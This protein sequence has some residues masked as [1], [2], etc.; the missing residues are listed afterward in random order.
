M[1]ANSD[2]VLESLRESAQKDTDLE[3]GKVTVRP[4]EE[5]LRRSLQAASNA[6]FC[7]LC[8][9][10]QGCVQAEGAMTGYDP[11][12]TSYQHYYQQGSKPLAIEYSINCGAAGQT[13]VGVTRADCAAVERRIGNLQSSA[14]LAEAHAESLIRAINTA[15]AT[16][17]F[18]Y[19]VVV[20][21]GVEIAATIRSPA[22]VMLPEI[23]PTNNWNG[24][25]PPPPPPVAVVNMPGV[26]PGVGISPSP[27]PIAAPTPSSQQC[28]SGDNSCEG[29]ICHY[30]GPGEHACQCTRGWQI[31]NSRST[32][33]GYTEQTCAFEC[34]TGYE[35]TGTHTCGADG[36]FTGGTCEP[37]ACTGGLTIANS[38]TTCSGVTLEECSYECNDGWEPTGSHICTPNGNFV[39]GACTTV[40]ACTA[41]EDDCDGR[42]CTHLGVNSHA[43]YCDTGNQ[44][45]NSQ[46]TCVGYT[47]Q[48]CAFECNAGYEPAGTHT[49]GA[50]GTFTGGT[51][52]PTACTGG[53]TIAN[54]PT[55]CSGVTLEECSYECNE[56]WQASGGS[57]ICM[58][59][60][61]FV[62]GSCAEINSCDV[63]EADDC[64]GRLCTHLSPGVHACYCDTGTTIPN[65]PTSCLGYTGQTCDFDCLPGYIATGIHTCAANGGFIGGSCAPIDCPANS[66]GE[67]V[68]LGCTCNDGFSGAIFATS[69]APF[70]TGSCEPSV[71]S[72]G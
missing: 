34:N 43:C 9:N 52:E 51:C 20:S 62:G 66:N 44:I 45:E 61:N 37:S 65:S 46:S 23:A 13:Y 27:T 12:P 7:V 67:N 39:G 25:P 56:G 36:T 69:T 17:N 70:F 68:G 63:D 53:L 30:L 60:G 1:G 19:N 40:N 15:A 50:D 35:P 14:V 57:H 54:S 2:T 21:S 58:P 8:G 18:N 5:I 49:C 55:T 24:V 47:G 11:D 6:P 48:T 32:C 42:L 31:T 59:N 71:I 33:V 22:P 26:T 41:D 64:Q 3:I 72:G 16:S 38:P 29:R 10:C 4:L 28:L